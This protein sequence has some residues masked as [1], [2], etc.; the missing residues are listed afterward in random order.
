MGL[1]GP[2]EGWVA[3]LPD[4]SVFVIKGCEH[5]LPCF[6]AVPKRLGYVRVRD[7]WTPTRLDSWSKCLEGHY[8][9]V[10]P[11]DSVAIINPVEFLE[12]LL[13]AGFMDEIIETLV[14]SVGEGVG[15][16]GSLVY[17]PWR[18]RDIDVVVYGCRGARRALEVVLE[19]WSKGVVESPG[20]GEY[21]ATRREMSIEDWATIAALNPLYF[22]HSSRAYSIKLVACTRP[23]RCKTRSRRLVETRVVV[24]RG[25]GVPCT[26]PR[27]YEAVADG[28]GRITVYTLR[29]SLS[30]MPGG[31]ILEGVM[32]LEELEDGGKRLVPD[33]G[34][35]GVQVLH[36]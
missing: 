26:I 1:E 4:G 19:L 18:S 2:V 29:S 16:T 13:A 30:C 3:I 14:S 23:I 17:E 27:L 11:E 15:V 32:A 33:G 24:A 31:T 12:R 28:F 10:C 36:A 34:V 8:P 25:R 20:L 21:Y 22:R 5:P 35:I 6:Y 7:P 9:I